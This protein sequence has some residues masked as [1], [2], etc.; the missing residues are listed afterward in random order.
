MALFHSDTGRFFRH[1]MRAYPLRSALM[2]V[3]LALAGLVEGFGVV[4]MLPLLEL[5]AGEGPEGPSG[6]SQVI[7]QVLGAIGLTPSLGVLLSVIVLAMAAKAAFLWLAMRQVGYTVAQVTTDL[8]MSL[9][10]ALLKARWS[11]YSSQSTGRFANAISSE[12]HRAASAYREGCVLIAGILQVLAYVVI[13]VLISWKMA[14]ATLVIGM[15]FLFLLR[16]FVQVAREAGA[17]QTDLMRSLIIRLTDALRGIKPIR[18]MG[19]ENHLQPLLE[20]ETEGLNQA[21]RRQVSAA[22]TLRLFQEPTVAAILGLGLFVALGVGDQPFA[23]VMILAFVF[24]RLMSHSNTLQTRYQTLAVGESAFWSLMEQVESAEQEAEETT[25][26]RAPQELKEGV[27]LSGVTFSYDKDPV[28]DEISLNIPAGSF[29]ALYGPSG[30]GKTTIADLVIGLHRPDSGTVEV[31]GVDLNEVDIIQWRRGLGYV[32][33]ELFLFHDTILRNVT[34]GDDS[35]TRSEVE[36]ALKASDAWAFVSERPEGIDH[37]IGEGGAMLSGGQRQRISVA[38][39][40][41]HRPSLLI[42]DEATASLDP[43]TEAEVLQTLRRLSRKVTILA[44]S[45]QPAL[46]DTAD[47]VYYLE[48]GRVTEVDGLSMAEPASL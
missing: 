26:R 9:L 20:T 13:A 15:L 1:F 19:R 25:G 22:E 29:V 11:Y 47:I 46:R 10:R 34:L 16:G 48:N 31:D 35:I 18:A 6:L 8:R 44:I 42:L 28:L 2:V 3:L 21:L 39:A 14:I 27:R 17:E 32:P 38:R 4:T 7:A 12:A 30:A 36:A 5:V 33:Q 41:V 40:L 23:S 37:V 45:H 24:Y 43:E